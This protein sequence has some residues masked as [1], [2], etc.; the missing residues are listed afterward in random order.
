MR[1][2]HISVTDVS[3]EI[4]ELKLLSQTAGAEIENIF[5]QNID[6]I[7]PATFIGKGKTEEI[8]QHCKDNK[9][10]LIIFNDDISPTQLKNLQKLA[11]EEIK[12][13]DRSGL[14][15]HIFKQHAQTKEAKTQ[16]ELASLEYLLPRL[17]RQWTHLERQMGGIGTRGGPGEA[18]I[19][20]DRRLINTQISRLKET[21]K[22]IENQR[23]TQN[24]RRKSEF[25]VA[26][27]GY[28]NAGKSTLMSVLTGEKVY[29][30]DQ[31]F[32]TLDTTTRKCNLNN[33][34]S[35]LI[36]DSVGFIR[37]LPHNL[38]ASFRST[39]GVLKEADLIL[40]II[41][42]SSNSIDL[43]INTIDKTIHSLDILHTKSI[44]VFNKIDL[45]QNSDD[46]K[47]L[48]GKYPNSIFI[49]AQQQLKIET[50][51]D[52][53]EKNIIENYVVS[54]L[55]IPYH[56]SSMVGVIYE[57]VEVVNQENNE[58]GI[59]LEVKGDRRVVESLKS[60]L[61]SNNLKSQ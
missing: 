45:I 60:K 27:A 29:I 40:K 12:I 8:I 16:V 30:K 6:K 1:F 51:V 19:E 10:P 52:R 44:L 9:I 56:F 37:K 34:L 49:S 18:Q 35:V 48:M 61:E 39:L 7:N 32:A 11:E 17:T 20:V 55:M 23:T 41:D 42:G 2:P 36:S 4:E 28:T 50:L 58:D 38:I 43:H 53:I 14:I 31:L 22:K 13:I 59:I 47:R 25:K 24:K 54:S 46:Y 3:E 21:L 57:S 33:H 5:F 26:L 15:I